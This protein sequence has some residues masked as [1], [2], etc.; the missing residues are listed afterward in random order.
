MQV[1]DEADAVV[2]DISAPEDAELVLSELVDAFR[3]EPQAA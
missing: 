1:S 3:G 2:V